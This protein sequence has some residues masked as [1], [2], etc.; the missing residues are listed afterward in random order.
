MKYVSAFALAIATLAV[1]GSAQADA[2]NQRYV[3]TAANPSARVTLA[4]DVRNVVIGN[5][6][7]LIKQGDSKVFDA[8]EDMSTARALQAQG[9]VKIVPI[10]ENRADEALWARAGGGEAQD[11][12]KESKSN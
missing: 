8:G 9:L 12:S 1:A 6:D 4:K 3:V 5:G 2:R 10:N 7:V 11:R